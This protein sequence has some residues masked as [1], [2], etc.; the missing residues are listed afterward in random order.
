MNPG[1]I[2]TETGDRLLTESGVDLLVVE[3]D[4]CYILAEAGSDFRLLTEAGDLLIYEGCEGAGAA[5]LTT[6]MMMGMGV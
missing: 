5:V 4:T 1:Y 3:S 6:R 2:L